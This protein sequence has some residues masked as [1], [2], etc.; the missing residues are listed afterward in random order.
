MMGIFSLFKVETEDQLVVNQGKWQLILKHRSV[1]TLDTIEREASKMK[2]KLTF[3]NADNSSDVI[4]ICGDN[5]LVQNIKKQLTE[6]LNKVFITAFLVSPLNLHE[7]LEDGT[8]KAESQQL[9]EKH[10]ILVSYDICELPSSLKSSVNDPTTPT[11]LI[12]ATSRAGSRVAVYSGGTFSYVKCDAIACFISTTPTVD[13][14]VLLSL[15]SAGGSELQHEVN[16]YLQSKCE[17]LP[18]TV[19]KI[20]TVGSLNCKAVYLTV[21]PCYND[22]LKSLVAKPQSYLVTAI[23]E[24]ITEA[25]RYSTD[26]VI[27]PISCAPLNY[28]IELFAEVLIQVLTDRNSEAESDLNFTIFVESSSCEAIFKSKMREYD[29]HIHYQHLPHPFQSPCEPVNHIHHQHLPHLSQP[30]SELSSVTVEQLKKAVKV[31]QGDMMS[32]QVTILM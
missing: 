1:T 12:K 5:M 16:S 6:L 3:P 18:A 4:H 27:A 11:L 20:S 28:P 9:E 22:D 23:N 14:L 19:H 26:I 17:L 32:I 10:K 8:I 2:V 21:L 24:L 15:M 13:D 25:I 29:Y 7:L 30:L 31:T